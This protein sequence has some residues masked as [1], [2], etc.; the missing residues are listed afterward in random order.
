MRPEDFA[1]REAVQNTSS[2]KGKLI[3]LDA[4]ELTAIL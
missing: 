3:V 4:K 1:L 2:V